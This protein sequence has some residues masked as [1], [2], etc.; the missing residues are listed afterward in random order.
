M[1]RDFEFFHGLAICKIIHFRKL[2][3]I[4]LYPSPSNSS[5]ILN[6]DFGIFIKYSTK[7]LSPWRYSFLKEH[8]DEIKKMADELGKVFIL[9]V[10]NNDGVV[11]LS[12]KELKQILNANHEETEWISATRRRREHYMI[13]GTDG[14]LKFKIGPGDF[15]KKLFQ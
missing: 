4:S 15:P 5:Y 12:Y 7:R 6:D 10:C 3:S 14:K 11:C 8:Q 13:K 1:G 9:L 2:H